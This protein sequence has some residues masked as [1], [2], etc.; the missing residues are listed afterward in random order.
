LAEKLV[1]ATES[2]HVAPGLTVS[3]AEA[4][5]GTSA[6]QICDVLDGGV[7]WAESLLLTGNP[8][9]RRPTLIATDAVSY[10]GLVV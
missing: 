5:Y 2:A 10:E 7:S 3:T 6:S 9:G 8:S 1:A 4:L